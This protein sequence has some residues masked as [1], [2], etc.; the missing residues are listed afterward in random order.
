MP[1]D[2][3]DYSAEKTKEEIARLANRSM[4]GEIDEPYL[5]WKTVVS[6]IFDAPTAD[7]EEVKHGKWILRGGWFRCS[8]CDGKALLK[9]VGG[10]GGLHEYDQVRS[11][12]CPHYGARMDGEDVRNG[13]RKRDC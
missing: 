9:D 4:V 5:D 11:D 12:I 7:V 8:E 6:V 1:D 2:A 3:T 10:T 13:Q